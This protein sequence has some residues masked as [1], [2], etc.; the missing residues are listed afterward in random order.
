MKKHWTQKLKKLG[1]C[2]NAVIWASEQQ[3]LEKAW[4]NCERGDWMLWLAGKTAGPSGDTRRKK[5]VLAAVECA[6]LS[7][8][9]VRA[10]EKRPAK[11]LRIAR[12][13]AIGGKSTLED[14]KSAAASAAEA[15]VAAADDAASVAAAAYAYAAAAASVASA[16]A[17]AAAYVAAASASSAAASAA[18]AYVAAA[19]DPASVAAS[20]SA[21]AS[22]ASARKKTLKQCSDIVRKYYSEPPK[23]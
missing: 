21:S 15:Y 12:D 5:L 7:I 2:E 14:V 4:Q 18:A 8:N 23:I 11:A 9:Y 22:A 19:D 1:A 3:N 6:Q 17:S 16:S 13:W 10:G 20:A